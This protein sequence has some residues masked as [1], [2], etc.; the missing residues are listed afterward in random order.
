MTDEEER[1]EIV[2]YWEVYGRVLRESRIAAEWPSTAP[3]PPAS[4][5]ETI[6]VWRADRDIEAL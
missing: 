6:L 2:R 3:P 4:P 1:A 5:G